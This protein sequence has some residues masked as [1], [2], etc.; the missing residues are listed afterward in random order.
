M[1]DIG[2]RAIDEYGITQE[3]LM[4]NS[5]Q[6][7]SF[8][9]L[10]KFGIKNKNFV[11]FCGAGHNGGNGLVVTRKIYSNDGK[12]TGFILSDHYKFQNASKQNFDIVSKNYIDK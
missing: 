1:S 7:A 6:A 5:C 10:K 4:E 11:N 3:I 2:R 8:S 9:I 12:V